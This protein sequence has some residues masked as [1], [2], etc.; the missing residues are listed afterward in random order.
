MVVLEGHERD[1]VKFAYFYGGFLS[2]CL[3]ENGGRD[4]DRDRGNGC[5]SDGESESDER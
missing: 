3:E 1:E 2:C 4:G 5:D